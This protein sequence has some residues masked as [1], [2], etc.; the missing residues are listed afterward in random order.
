[1]FLPVPS[2]V[3][4]AWGL[5]KGTEV[6]IEVTQNE[7]R[8]TPIAKIRGEPVSEADLQRFWE[9]MRQVEI[10]MTVEDEGS[11]LRVQFS[12]GDAEARRALVQNLQRV[13]PAVLS[14]IGVRAG[15]ERT[16]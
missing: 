14:M 13:L 6:H 3:V 1:M 4:D 2:M 10:K 12:G 11:S 8:I 16:G 5:E 9:L 15:G 7:M